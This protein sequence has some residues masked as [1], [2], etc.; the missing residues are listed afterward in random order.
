M[1]AERWVHPPVMAREAPPAWRAAWRFR[2]L[3]LLLLALL[4]VA[5]VVAFRQFTG[6][7][8][9]DPGVGAL[10]SPLVL[11]NAVPS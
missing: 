8:A 1:A 10:S 9:Q 3:S 7:N 11:L 4:V 2:L 5:G 6:A